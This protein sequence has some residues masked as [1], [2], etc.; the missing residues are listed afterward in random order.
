MH[1]FA[2][3]ADD[4]TWRSPESKGGIKWFNRMEIG[5]TSI[6]LGAARVVCLFELEPKSPE[7]KKNRARTEITL[8][9]SAM[10]W[11]DPVGLGL[12]VLVMSASTTGFPG[13]R[14]LPPL[15]A[16]ITPPPRAAAPGLGGGAEAEPERTPPWNATG[17]SKSRGYDFY[18]QRPPW[19]A[20]RPRG[21]WLRT[22]PPEVKPAR[23]LGAA[24]RARG[25]RGGAPVAARRGIR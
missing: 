10:A 24:A 9:T 11:T 15:P 12:P 17:S 23:T 5:I 18:L 25:E 20:Q 7:E 13:D 16:G 8:R 22:P 14:R 6:Q 3:Q 21:L 4:A 19:L 1:T 2:Q